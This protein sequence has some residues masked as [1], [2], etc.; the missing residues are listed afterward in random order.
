MPAAIGVRVYQLLVFKKGDKDPKYFN[1][2]ALHIPTPKFI[3]KFVER[4]KEA[5]RD[6]ER[7]RSWF[8]EP[9]DDD[10]DG[11]G[12]GYVQYGTFGFESNFVDVS[13]KVTNYRRKTSDTEEIPLYY[14]FWC[15]T[16]REYGLVIMQ[17]FQGRSC[18]GMVVDRLKTDFEK[19]NPGYRLQYRKL[20]PN[21]T[22]GSVYSSAPV[23]RLTLIKHR[24]PRDL[25]DEYYA[26]HGHASVDF[27]VSL[28]ARR[29]GF[30]GDLGAVSGMIDK[31]QTGVIVHHDIAFDEAIAEIRVGNKIRRVGVF[32]SESDAGVIDLT[33]DVKRGA[34]GHPTLESI[35]EHADDILN[36][37]HSM[38]P[39]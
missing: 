26:I 5:T 38:L 2:P 7:E 32:G 3:S 22:H 9:S 21:D 18:V 12:R 19:E 15:P 1:H 20:S 37:F 35:A 39:S 4:N 17:S 25:T 8:F 10:G 27:E 28:K 11:S 16:D 36:A 33:N 6:N 23:R 13:T 29:N 24:A 30:L 31:D 34:D 14:E